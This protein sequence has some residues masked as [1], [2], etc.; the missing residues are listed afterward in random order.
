MQASLSKSKRPPVFCAMRLLLSLVLI[1]AGGQGGG[2][3]LLVQQIEALGPRQWIG[4]VAVSF[5]PAAPLTQR[6]AGSFSRKSISSP[7]ESSVEA[8]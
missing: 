8:S 4:L 3:R 1:A 6:I 5:I 7:S 2:F